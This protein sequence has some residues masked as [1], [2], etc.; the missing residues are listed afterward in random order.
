MNKAVLGKTIKIAFAAVAAI[1]VADLLHLEYAVT[2]GIITILSIQ[3]TKKETFKTAWNRGVAF[4][5]ALLL[6]VLCFYF[7]GFHIASFTLYLFLFTLI[8]LNA[9][10]PEAIAMDSVL[11]SHF[12]T[13]QSIEVPVIIN[14]ILL[15]AIGTACGILINL[16]LHRSEEEFNRLSLEVDEEIRRI[17]HRM[18]HDISIEDRQ[19]YKQDCFE[20]LE[21][22][23]EC[24]KNCALR[25]WNNTL[26]GE[27]QQE[28]D[29]IKMRENQSR[30]LR[31]IYQSI[32][33]IRVL[34]QQTQSV[35]QFIS[36]IETE[37]H[38]ENDCTE[39]LVQL[40]MIFSQMKK[41]PLPQTREE[42]EARA[43]L[44]Y[45]MKQIQEFLIL[46][47]QFIR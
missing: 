7:L 46:K 43:I 21:D 33:M 18:S 28:I 5:C 30:V 41:E 22:K 13:K 47:N 11:I 31:N 8:C 12:L 42:F 35:A 27:S 26:W 10:W 15:F 20:L 6:A 1:L 34:P 44:F 36:Q 17:L 2:A 45:I 23:I 40:E 9:N 37:Y 25:N 39:L 38:R 16:H 24:A 32:T 4:A 14:E 19:L 3:N 29:Y